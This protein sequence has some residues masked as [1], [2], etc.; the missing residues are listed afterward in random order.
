MGLS[1]LGQLCALCTF[2]SRSMQPSSRVIHVLVTREPPID[3]LP[4]EGQYHV[5]HIGSGSTIF[6]TLIGHCGQA[7]AFV[8][9]PVCQESR[10]GGYLRTVELKLDSAIKTNAKMAGFSVTHRSLL[11]KRPRRTLSLAY[12]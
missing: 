9:F 8:E 11:P 6:E 10:I 3:R 1:S 5:L 7:E 12:G 4:Q 2:P